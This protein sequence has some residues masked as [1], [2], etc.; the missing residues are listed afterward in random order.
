MGWEWGGGRKER[1]KGKKKKKTTTQV[2]KQKSLFSVLEV[3]SCSPKFMQEVCTSGN[4]DIPLLLTCVAA[5]VELLQSCCV[6]PVLLPGRSNTSLVTVQL[7]QSKAEALNIGFGKEATQQV[8]ETYIPRERR[9][10][11]PGT[12]SPKKGSGF[13]QM[14]LSR[15]ALYTH[16]WCPLPSHIWGMGGQRRNDKWHFTHL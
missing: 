15:A 10:C 14:S 1:R 13:W 5:E 9:G 11:D 12:S 8:K 7:Q 3:M 4:V 6:S 2:W 16:S